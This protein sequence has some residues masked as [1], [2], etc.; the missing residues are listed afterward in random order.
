M[1]CEAVIF[2]MDGIIIDSEPFWRT[3]QRKCFEYVGIVLSEQDCMDTTG[4]RIGDIIELRYK[5]KPWDLNEISMNKLKDMI[6]N[7]IVSIVLEKGE[8]LPG[9]EY[10]LDY[11]VNVKGIKKIGIASSSPMILINAVCKRLSH[12][13]KGRIIVHKS[14]D[15]LKYGKPNP[16]VYINCADALGVNPRNCL[17][18]EDSITGLLSGKSA[19]MKVI[20]IPQHYPIKKGYYVADKIFKSLNDMNDDVFNELFPSIKSKL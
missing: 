18:F 20:A 8:S 5:E 1:S 6:M 3:A 17:V 14:A 12:I 2:D 16:Q 7:E 11:F 10:A 13:I 19:E 9:F 15:K 4:T